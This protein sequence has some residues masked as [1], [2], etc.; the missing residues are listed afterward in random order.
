MS[1]H[2]PG[3]W[4]A[5]DRRAGPNREWVVHRAD[6]PIIAL[7]A[8]GEADARLIAAAPELLEVAKLAFERFRHGGEMDMAKLAAAIAK[9]TVKP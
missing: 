2:T 6:G 1:G 4:R 3:P 5:L 9:A 8:I 7:A